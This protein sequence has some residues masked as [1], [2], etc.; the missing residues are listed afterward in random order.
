MDVLAGSRGGK[1]SGRNAAGGGAASAPADD[2]AKMRA[3]V[4]IAAALA[5]V[6]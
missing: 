6:R 1:G 5:Q 2:G 3:E 4:I